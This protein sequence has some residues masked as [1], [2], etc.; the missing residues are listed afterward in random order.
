MKTEY[1]NIFFG[2]MPSDDF[3]E[4]L[5]ELKSFERDEVIDIIDRIFDWYPRDDIEEEW[6]KWKSGLS[7][8][9]VDK[10]ERVLRFLLFLIKEIAAER[11]SKTEIKED[12]KNLDFPKEYLEYILSKLESAGNF[13]KRALKAKRPFENLIRNIDWRVDERKFADGTKQTIIVLEVLY[14]NKGEKETVNFELNK[15][16]I[17]HFINILKIIEKAL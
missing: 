1:L 11:I 8:D 4:D 16:G 15:K 9:V 5:I 13:K 10:K 2:Q 3:L 6:E 12:L 14:Y 17:K 7:E